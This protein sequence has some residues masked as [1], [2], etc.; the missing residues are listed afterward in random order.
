MV[1]VQVQFLLTQ[2]NIPEI[3]RALLDRSPVAPP[4]PPL[5]QVMLW[6]LSIH[7]PPWAQSVAH[8]I[9]ATQLAARPGAEP[10]AIDHSSEVHGLRRK[11]AGE[12]LYRIMQNRCFPKRSGVFLLGTSVH[13]DLAE[14]SSTTYCVTGEPSQRTLA[15]KSDA[16][17]NRRPCAETL[18]TLRTPVPGKVLSTA[19]LP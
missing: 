15:P 11:L 3:L 7:G 14:V 13:L 12:P 10:N 19:K 1:I 17:G 4:P 6:G 5:K 18:C 8:A 2:T 16:V 9:G